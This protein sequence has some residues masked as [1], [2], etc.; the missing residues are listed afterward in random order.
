[1]DKFFTINRNGCSIRC[2]LYAREGRDVQRLVLYGHG[3]GGHKDN[4]AAGR[5]AEYILAKQKGSALLC[6]D[7]PCHGE[8]ARKK[9]SLGDCDLYLRSV[10]EYSR[11]TYPQAALL[12]YATSFGAYL[13]LKYMAERG[14]PFQKAAFRC[15]AVPMYEVL[16]GSIVRPEE[17]EMLAKGKDVLVGFDRKI[18]I[19]RDFL[20]SLRE[21]DLD[22]WDFTPYC[23]DILILHGTRDEIVPMAAAEA[24][25]DRN[26]IPFFPIENADHRFVDPGRM[27]EAIKLIADFLE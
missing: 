1:M 21:A 8:D 27:Q 10:I 6:F 23:D 25:A 19:S 22:R 9:L 16:T 24:F 11:E 17:A 20:E 7:W 5:F 3:F 14:N 2:K 15:P 4:R 26:H 12:A 18:K 13:F